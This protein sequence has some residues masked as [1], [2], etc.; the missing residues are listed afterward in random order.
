MKT[1]DLL[2]M[3]RTEA[4]D[5]KGF[6]HRINVCC[7]SGCIPL[8]AL[9][10]LKAFEEAVKDHGKEDECK[11]ARTGCVGTCYV[12]PAVVVEPGDYLYQGVTPETAREIVEGHIV[13]GKPVKKLLYK[14]AEFFDKQKK[15]RILRPGQVPD[16]DGAQ[17][18]DR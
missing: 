13:K 10:V 16:R 14:K 17:A 18:G 2:K 9:E 5:Q 6:K 11:V 15:R 12:G 4:E 1:S 7:S 8:G 3:A